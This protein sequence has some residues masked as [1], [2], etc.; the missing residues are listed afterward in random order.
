MAGKQKMVAGHWIPEMC[1]KTDLSVLLNLSVRALSDLDAKGVLMKAPK[2]GTYFT[3]QSVANYIEK[4]RAAAAGREEGQRNPLN[5]E[6]VASERINRQISEVK[7]AQMRGEMLTLDEVTES[8]TKF[9]AVVKAAALSLPTKAR[10]MIPHLTAHDA[11]TIRT[12]VKDMLNDLADEVE[13]S[14]IAGDPDNVA[15]DK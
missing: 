1:T 6:R 5:D 14:V 15:P 9:A 7:L 3:R 4:I 13:A 8:W 11:E 12:L 2:N 10:T